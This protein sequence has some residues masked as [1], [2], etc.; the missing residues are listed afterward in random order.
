MKKISVILLLL[1][2]A[3][4]RVFS[5][6][7]VTAIGL[8]GG[9]AVGINFKYFLTISSSLEAIAATRERGYLFTGLYEFQTRAFRVRHFYW[10]YGG[11]AHAGYWRYYDGIK[12]V[13]PG[14]DVFVVGIDGITG[15]EYN[16]MEFPITISLDMKPALNFIGYKKP[17][18]DTAISLRYRIN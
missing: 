16:I 7:Y 5:Q 6:D 14:E 3:G 9:T 1:F 13:D 18:F 15:L 17:W 8:R 11:G 10:F 12:W 4:S 2:L